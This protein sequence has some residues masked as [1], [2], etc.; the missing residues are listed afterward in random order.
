MSVPECC[1][2][3]TD[4][5]TDLRREGFVVPLNIEKKELTAQ[6]LTRNEQI[7]LYWHRFFGH[8]S[9]KKICQLIQEKMCNGLPKSLPKG[10]VPC[11]VCARGKSINKN[12]LS[13]S[14]RKFEKLEVV[15][16]DLMGPFEVETFNKGKY[17][18]TIRDMATGFS[19]AKVLESKDRVCDLLTET[20]LRWERQTSKKVK[21]LRTDNGG[22]FSSKVLDLFI[23]SHG[24]KA[25]RALPYHHYQ[26]G[27]IECFNQTVADMGRTILIESEMGKSFWGFAFIW[28]CDILNIIPNKRSGQLTPYQAFYGVKPTF[29]R[30]KFFGQRAFIHVQAE[31]RKKLDNRAL[32]G[33]VV[34][35]C[36]D[37]KSWVFFMK[38][39]NDLVASAIVEWVEKKPP[40][41]DPADTLAPKT[42]LTKQPRPP[43]TNLQITDPR[44]VSNQDKPQDP[45]TVSL[46]DNTVAQKAST[47]PYS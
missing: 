7:L 10:D 43:P 8:A 17:L 21:I 39:T 33:R 15:T 4:L 38:D 42:S 27:V 24:I 34:A 6:S 5:R 47:V 2:I 30:A 31:N 22:E 44:Q 1:P 25:E 12:C 19:E 37:S 32:E 18:L 26:K 40:V 3:S 13:R 9:L 46:R 14:G 23:K 28:A 35:H 45:S 16:A 20:V 41:F 36:D 29:D 11:D